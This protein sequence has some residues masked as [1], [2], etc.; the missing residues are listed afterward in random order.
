ML[1]H[2]HLGQTSGKSSALPV[3][4]VV[5]A[6][7]V[8]RQFQNGIFFALVQLNSVTGLVHNV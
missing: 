7:P 5:Q 3:A 8:V 2:T 6:G 4:S 1:Q